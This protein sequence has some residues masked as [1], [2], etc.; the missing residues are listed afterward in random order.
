MN[1]TTLAWSR[2]WLN[3]QAAGLTGNLWS[4]EDL[5][6]LVFVWGRDLL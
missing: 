2:K 6:V 4:L 1:R 5:V 3:H